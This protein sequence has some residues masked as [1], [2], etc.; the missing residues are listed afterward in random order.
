VP[1]DQLVDGG[2]FVDLAQRATG[3]EANQHL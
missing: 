3:I 1:G 2:D